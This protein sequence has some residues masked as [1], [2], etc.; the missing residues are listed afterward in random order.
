MKLFILS[1]LVFLVACVG[2][3][4]IDDYNM[5]YTAINAAKQAGAARFATGFLTKANDYYKQAQKHYSDRDYEKAS[6]AFKQAKLFAERAENVSALKRAQT[7]EVP[8]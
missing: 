5:A 4:P 8:E 7:G 1:A 3:A 2:P 6:L